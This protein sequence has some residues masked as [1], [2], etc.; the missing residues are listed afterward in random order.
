MSTQQTYSAEKLAGLLGLS[1]RTVLEWINAGCPAEKVGRAYERE[2]KVA[3]SRGDAAESSPA[4]V[5]ALLE[6]EI[7]THALTAPSTSFDEQSTSL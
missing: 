1:S 3:A 5:R 6:T 7:E 4:K 2:I